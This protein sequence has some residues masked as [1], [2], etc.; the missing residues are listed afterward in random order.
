MIVHTH[1]YLHFS[2]ALPGLFPPFLHSLHL[3]SFAVTIVTSRP[4]P[5][6]LTVKRAMMNGIRGKA[7]KAPVTILS[8]PYS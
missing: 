1:V 7:V 2:T 4:Q 3:I 6:F 5:Q 8:F